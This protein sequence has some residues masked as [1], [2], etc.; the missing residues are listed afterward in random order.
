MHRRWRVSRTNNEYLQYL[1][2]TTG[3]SPVF[4][5]ILINRGIKEPSSVRTFL[6]PSLSDLYDPML[7]PDMK[8][9]VSRI[10]KARERD[11]T[12]L[13]HGDYDADGITATTI[14]MG[15]LKRLGFRALYYIP[16]RILEGYGISEKCIE[17]A[18]SRGVS[19]IITADCGISAHKSIELA[20]EAG[21]DV[22][23]TDHHEPPEGLPK[24]CAIV[25]PRRRDSLYP[26]NNLAGVGVAY[27]LAQ[28]I[29]GETGT[30][31][32]HIYLRNVL[33][34]VA[35]GTVA[36][37]VPL[38]EENRIF[39]KYGLEIINNSGCRPGIEALKKVACINTPLRAE[40]LSYT[41]IPR[42][43]A[44]GRLSDASMVV[45]LLLTEDK[46][47]AESIAGVLEEHNKQRQDVE[48]RILDEALNMI[49]RE[50]LGEAIV[51]ASKEWHEGVIGI[52][53][54]RL[55]EMFY[56]PVFLF[57]IRDGIGKGSARSIP[58]LNIYEVIHECNDLLLGYGGHRQAAGMRIKE[59]N[60][61]GFNERVIQTIRGRLSPEDFIPVLELD[62][63]VK[64]SDLDFRLIQEFEKLEPYGEAN[65]EPLLGTKKVKIVQQR[66]V[67]NNHLRMILR[68]DDI[69][70]E[71]IAFGM[72]DMME[73]FTPDSLVDIA[74]VPAI[75]E[76]NS[77]RSLQLNLK[78][79][80]PSI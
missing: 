37:S 31:D 62:A 63:S 23:I 64:F 26:F 25:N 45:E 22:I 33:D 41:L 67:G 20:K 66:I 42:I 50:R 19:L 49:E 36:D 9:A 12:I 2:K 54:S 57:A 34:I 53:A 44:A 10:L 51:L 1:S 74:F 17:D 32:D 27:K 5:Q 61:E 70:L 48:S 58:P 65:N 80:R 35:L 29:V 69:H 55:V 73:K 11:E 21:I 4:A 60:I 79:I 8:E 75:N 43:N 24:A 52:V 14:L 39:V 16:N 28:A 78:G 47:K 46:E 56:R 72:G 3:V 59:E 77:T 76:W 68:Q 71:T 18:K 30:E 6:S 15:T 40:L 7:M 38:I 13:I